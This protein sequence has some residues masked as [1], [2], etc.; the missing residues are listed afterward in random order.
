MFLASVLLILQIV[1]PPV[2]VTKYELGIFASG[3]SPTTGSPFQ[4][5][6]YPLALVSCGHLVS[7]TA[8]DNVPNPEVFVFDDPNAAGKECR[9]NVRTVVASL[10]LGTGYHAALRSVQ[11][12]DQRSS[13]TLIPYTFRRAPRGFPCAMGTGVESNVEADIN[14]KPVRL[15]ICIQP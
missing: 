3:V 5:T 1:T 13:W 10:P 15:T 11:S 7:E 2:T 8:V 6:V 14:G 9:I 12:D 4:I